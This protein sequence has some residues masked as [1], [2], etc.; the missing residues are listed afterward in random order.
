MIVC[1]DFH[2]KV[3]LVCTYVDISI[4]KDV[5]K[6]QAHQTPEVQAIVPED[7][8]AVDEQ[9]IVPEVQAAADE[10]ATVPE[11]QAAEEVIQ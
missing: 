8:A 5:K 6:F 2:S 3:V 1:Y 9:A 4:A 10:Q 11:V 7:Q